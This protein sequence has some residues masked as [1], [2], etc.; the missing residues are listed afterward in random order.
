MMFQTASIVQALL[1][2]R[3]LLGSA[4]AFALHLNEKTEPGA[5]SLNFLNSCCCFSIAIRA[6]VGNRCVTTGCGV[7]ASSVASI[8]DK[9]EVFF[10]ELFLAALLSLAAL[11][12][13][14]SS[15]DR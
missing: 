13:L 14:S 15:E 4:V 11:A 8:Q 6:S 12:D 2:K 7:K 1:I 5:T 9:P 10:Q 3:S